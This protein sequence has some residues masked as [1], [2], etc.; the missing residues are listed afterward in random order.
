MDSFVEDSA[1]FDEGSNNQENYL[2]VNHQANQVSGTNGTVIL[3]V[4]ETWDGEDMKAILLID[5]EIEKKAGMVSMTVSLELELP[6][7]CHYSPQFPWQ[8]LD[9]NEGNSEPY[10]SAGSRTPQSIVD[11]R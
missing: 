7:F 8:E 11:A 10:S 5:W 1:N 2:H 3:E 9:A 4:P 6:H